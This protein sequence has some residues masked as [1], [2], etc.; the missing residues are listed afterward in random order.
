MLIAGYSSVLPLAIVP[1]ILGGLI[2]ANNLLGGGRT[3]GRTPGRPIGAG[4]APLSSSGPNG[5]LVDPTEEPVATGPEGSTSPVSPVS[6][7]SPG[8]PA[9]PDVPVDGA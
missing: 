2:G 7:V 9:S 3:Y 6:P 5:P 1:L 8:V 4:Q